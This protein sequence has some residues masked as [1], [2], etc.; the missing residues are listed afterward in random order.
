MQFKGKKIELDE[1]PPD[2]TLGQLKQRL[3]EHTRVLPKRQKLFGLKMVRVAHPHVPPPCPH[4][5]ADP[6]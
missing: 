6:P 5:A 1:F 4:L 2:S 3:F